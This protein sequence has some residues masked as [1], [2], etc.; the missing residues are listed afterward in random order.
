MADFP[1]YRTLDDMPGFRFGSGGTLETDRPWGFHGSMAR[2]GVW[3]PVAVRP[4]VHTGYGQFGITCD[5]KTLNKALHVLMCRAFH[6]PRP[7]G[8]YVCFLD[9]D[10]TNC[11]A[12]NLAWMSKSDIMKRAWS[13]R[14]GVAV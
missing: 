12:D 11:R 3:R 14:K 2:A 4:N 8:H 10:R 7:A 1:E 6:G 5:G 13:R 9:G